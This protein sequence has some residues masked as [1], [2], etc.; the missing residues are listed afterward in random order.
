[1]F[2][3]S[4]VKMPSTELIISHWAYSV[5]RQ[6]HYPSTITYKKSHGLLSI[7]FWFRFD[8]KRNIQYRRKTELLMKHYAFWALGFESS[9]WSVKLSHDEF[10]F[11]FLA[12]EKKDFP[13]F[14]CFFSFFFSFSLSFFYTHLIWFIEIILIFS[15]VY[16]VQIHK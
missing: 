15:Y 13:L 9:C 8:K 14:C 10:N 7:I 11:L 12:N 6:H 2:L 3:R 5:R 4:S 1:M 16:S